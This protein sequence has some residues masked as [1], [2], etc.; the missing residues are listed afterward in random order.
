MDKLRYP[1]PGSAPATLMVPLEYQTVKPV[2]SLIQYDAHKFEERVIETIDQLLPCLESEK[3]SWI[4]IN[5]LGDV[6]L[7]KQLAAHFRIHQLALEDI[8]NLGQRPKVDEYDRQL[9][10]VLDMAYETQKDEI[11]F[12]QIS[13]VL[14]EYIVITV[15]ERPGDVLN[16]V[17]QRLRDAAGNARFLRADYLA[18][19]LIDSI[20]DHY[21]PI[22]ESLGTSMDDFHQTLLNQPTR[23]RLN[24]LHAFRRLIARIRHAVWPHRDVLN[25]LMRD[26]S[27]IISG[28][29]RPYL[30]DCYDNTVVMLDMLE[31]FRDATANFMDL[32]HS[33]IGIRT[34]EIIRVLTLI[35]S[36][37]IPLTFIAGIYGMNFDPK[38]SPLNMPE[39][40]WP[41]GYLFAICLMLAVAGAIILYFKR[42]KWL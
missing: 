10:I 13:I 23:E 20:V 9:F 31:T 28:R 12:E 14:T 40:E 30:R 27:G 35:S 22:I 26:E 4:N 18:Y 5:G 21:F 33:S 19:A 11:T 25:R 17:R 8:L 16:P 7:F 2:V 36:I 38:A 37:F 29:T 6:E 32:Y 39:L 1:P 15:Q 41:F 3:I 24:E 42:K 34:N